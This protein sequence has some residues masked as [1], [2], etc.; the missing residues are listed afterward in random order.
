MFIFKL[1]LCMCWIL[2]VLLFILII[3]NLL[4][5]FLDVI[6]ICSLCFGLRMNEELSVWNLLLLIEVSLFICIDGRSGFMIEL[7]IDLL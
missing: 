1:I 4:F 2:S 7:F 5:F 3:G 6:L